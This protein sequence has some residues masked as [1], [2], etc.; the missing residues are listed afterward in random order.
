M[1]FEVV[2]IGPAGMLWRWQIM[3]NQ[4]VPPKVLCTSS[5]HNH[6]PLCRD[7]LNHVIEACRQETRPIIT[8]VPFGP[9]GR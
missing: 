1:R 5:D 4:Q 9:T 8:T 7:E 2:E 3:D 6:E